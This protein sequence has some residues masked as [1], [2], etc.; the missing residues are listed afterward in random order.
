MAPPPIEI[1][2]LRL[3]IVAKVDV[4]LV[5]NRRTEVNGPNSPRWNSVLFGTASF[6]SMDRRRAITDTVYLFR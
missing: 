2:C 4:N 6:I 5:K 3:G 1:M